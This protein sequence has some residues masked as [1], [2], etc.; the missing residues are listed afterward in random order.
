M[1]LKIDKSVRLGSTVFTLTGRIEEEHIAELKK[2][3]EG[4]KNLRNVVVDLREIRQADRDAV[5]FLVLCQADGI[6]VQNCPAYIREW[7]EREKD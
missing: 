2:L 3:F 6:H 4:E 1:T 5:K 7:M